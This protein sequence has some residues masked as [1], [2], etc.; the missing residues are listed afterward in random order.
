MS[1][2]NDNPDFVPHFVTESNDSERHK[3]IVEIPD[4]SNFEY[5]QERKPLSNKT[6]ELVTQAMKDDPLPTGDI[7]EYTLDNIDGYAFY[8]LLRIAFKTEGLSARDNYN[9]AKR[10]ASEWLSRAGIVGIHYIGRVDG[11]CYV[12][13]NDKDAK[14]TDHIRFRRE[15]REKIRKD[16]IE[17]GTW[18]KAPNGENSNLSEMDWVTVRTKAFKDWFGDWAD[19]NSSHSLIVDSNGEPLPVYHYTSEDFTVFDRSKARKATDVDGFFFAPSHEDWSAMGDKLITAFLNIRRPAINPVLALGQT[20]DAGVKERLRLE[21]EG[22][23]GIINGDSEEGIEYVAFY[24]NQI[25]RTDGEAFSPNSDDIRFRRKKAH[26]AG[27]HTL[28]TDNLR[29]ALKMGGLANPSIA[30]YDTERGLPTRTFGEVALIAPRDL[31]DANTG[32]HKG[33]YNRD[34]WSPVYPRIA[35]DLTEKGHDLMRELD[36][37]RGEREGSL[38]ALHDLVM[39]EPK[40]L[41]KDYFIKLL[42]VDPQIKELYRNETPSIPFDQYVE[43]IAEPILK[44]RREMLYAGQNPDGSKRY[45]PHNLENVAKVMN[46][47]F[48]KIAPWDLFMESLVDLSEKYKSLES[49]RRHEDRM[50]GMDDS[51]YKKVEREFHYLAEELVSDKTE[52]M[53]PAEP[54]KKLQALIVNNDNRYGRPLTVTEEARVSALREQMKALPTDYFETKVDRPVGLSEF[55]E[56]V[57]PE[58]TSS[59][60]V[61]E[62]EKSGLKVSTYDSAKEGAMNEAVLSAMDR[63]DATD[64]GVRFRTGEQ[65]IEEVNRTF[66]EELEKFLAG[67]LSGGHAFNLGLPGAILRATGIPALP[68]R[69]TGYQITKKAKDIKHPF[70]PTILRNLPEALQSPVAVFTYGKN[71][72]MRNIIVDIDYNGE[73]ILIGLVMNK[74]QS[75]LK[76]NDIKGL[77]PK[78]TSNW[79]RWIADEKDLYLNS[80]KIQAL[81]EARQTNPDSQ[82]LLDLDLIAK[83]QERLEETKHRDEMIARAEL[84]EGEIDGEKALDWLGIAPPKGAS[85]QAD[86]KLRNIANITNGFENPKV[87]KETPTDP[88]HRFR[89]AERA[90]D[91]SGAAEAAIDFMRNAT[92][93]NTTIDDVL[94]FKRVYHNSPHLLKKADGSFVDPDTGERLGFDHRFMGSGEGAQ[95]HGWGS[96]FSVKDLA[97]YASTYDPSVYHGMRITQNDE[98]VI[99]N[100]G[101]AKTSELLFETVYGLCKSCETAPD[102]DAIKRYVIETITS[103]FQEHQQEANRQRRLLDALKDNEPW[104]VTVTNAQAGDIIT[105]PKTGY[106]YIRG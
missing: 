4:P 31:V 63:A 88:K 60:L 77:F 50:A 73:N 25:K 26:L 78:S 37:K 18:M 9:N 74:R 94:R 55:V 45:V 2:I 1:F 58:G 56:A 67:G 101:N 17:D 33:T 62:L 8:D 43:K 14:I 95:A 85:A 57:V 7:P 72:D 41:D 69:I 53:Y 10:A 40:I 39:E 52:T 102:E 48:S 36:K 23:D 20:Y 59:E 61:S 24:P 15:E 86:P 98:Y 12:I 92:P 93:K 22:Y 5:I 80:K 91:V 97:D 16:A 87:D 66:N 90:G 81:V 96:Y 13:F 30:V 3:Y 44:E 38:Y 28:T 100:G 68:I 82:P 106:R 105:D 70:T 75:N 11:E 27:V 46:E 42:S 34:S 103:R 76:I 65:N 19:R 47:D 89:R 6:K 83:V 51:L 35:Y 54:A 71:K 29:H 32:R 99:S 84:Q 21:R 64:R 49:I 79:L 104:A